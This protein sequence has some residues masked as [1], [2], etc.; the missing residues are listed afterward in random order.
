VGDSQ[1]YE[2]ERVN[3]AGHFVI[4]S[5]TCGTGCHYLFMWDAINGKVYQRLPP[6][7]I[8][9]GPFNSG[10]DELIEYKGEDRAD[11][12]LLI[13][14]ACVEASCDCATRYYKGTAGF[15]LD[16]A[17]AIATACKVH[18]MARRA[19]ENDF[20]PLQ[21]VPSRSQATV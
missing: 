21:R 11:S 4:D 6:G 17:S 15:R 10:T 5:C 14:D 18:V 19:N 9:V 7:V 13:V 8:D 20:K 3:F 2:T 16:S 12:S 1:V